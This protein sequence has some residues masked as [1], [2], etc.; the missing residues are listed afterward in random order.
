[1]VSNDELLKK[2]RSAFN[3]NIYEAKVWLAILSR[4]V[5][6]AGELS[7]MSNVPRSRSY[8]VLE[9]LE[10]KGFII[11][12]LGR[13]IQYLAVQPQ[14]I[15]K[16]VKKQITEKAEE[17][18]VSLQKLE[19][20]DVYDELNGLFKHGIQHVDPTTIAG[21]FQ[22]R[23]S[24]Y[25][26]LGSML[27]NAQKEVT[28]VTTADGIARKFESLRNTFKKL[29]QNKVKITIIAPLRTERA[30]TAAK[31]LE[32]YATIKDADLNARF[33]LIDNQEIMFMVNHDKEVHESVDTAIWTKSP[34]FASTLKT[35]CDSFLNG[36]K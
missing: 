19:G 18:V 23:S 35:F 6:T 24:I 13:P 30:K 2:L 22:G 7:D 17:E 3:L 11:M 36:K 16:R 8:D 33:V 32:E 15:L 1:M 34:F 26:H 20:T 4:G 31:E 29:K 21:S 25:A 14:E 28:V 5:A 12:K 27:Q 10:K 9:G